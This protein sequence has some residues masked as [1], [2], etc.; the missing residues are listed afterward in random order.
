MIDQNAPT[1]G[2]HS[3]VPAGAMDWPAEIGPYR[4]VEK[5]GQGGMGLVLLGQSETPKR[6]AAIKLMRADA[7]DPDALARFR[8]EMEVLARLEHR[9]IARLY[10]VG[11]LN[12]GAGEKPWYAME[13]VAGLPLDEYVKRHNLSVREILS[14]VSEIARALQFA[15]QKGVIH[16]DIKPA[17]ILVDA[18]GQA[19]LLDFGIA[20]LNDGQ[21]AD[22]RT[23]FGQIIGT[24][25]YMSPEQLASSSQ[26]DV[27]SDVYALGVVLF[28]LLTGE[29]PLKIGTTS[30][31][32]AIKEV[33]EG[34]RK[35]LVEIR[36]EL[37]GEIALIVDTASSRE[38]A[39]R[40]ESASSFAADLENFLAHRPLLAKRPSFFYVFS[41]FVRR[42]PLVVAASALALAALLFATLYSLAAAKKEAQARQSA[43]AAKVQ[44]EARAA[45]ASA[46]LKFLNDAL[47]SAA[48]DRSRGREVKII[49]MLAQASAQRFPVAQAN[50]EAKVRETLLE[51]Y[52]ALGAYPEAQAE[53][54]RLRA[55]CKLA[56]PQL[57]DSCVL[58]EARQ[59]RVLTLNGKHEQALA[60]AQ[61]ALPK[62]RTHFGA[63][64]L[65]AIDQQIELGE[66]YGRLGNSKQALIE[67][68]AAIAQ[69]EN[70]EVVDARAELKFR[71][72][73]SDA[74]SELGELDESESVLMAA[75]ARAE[76]GLG[77]DH[78]T[79]LLARNS[80][81][82]INFQRE[83][84]A[85]AAND[86]ETLLIQAQKVLGPEHRITMTVLGNLAAAQ[87]VLGELAKAEE[88]FSKRAEVFARK[89]PDDWGSIL[90]NAVNRA[91]VQSK[92]QRFERGLSDINAAIEAANRAR[93]DSFPAQLANAYNWQAYFTWKLGQLTKAEA[94]YAELVAKFVAQFGEGDVQ[95]ARYRSRLGQV[96]LALKKREQGRAL[97]EQALP[98]LVKAY[99]DKHQSVLEAQA[100]LVQ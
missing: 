86:F 45:E 61:T 84:Y 68:R 51:S 58:L 15:H 85:R 76:A 65:P 4:I 33:S 92:R 70:S 13:F 96:K 80:L 54:E 7:F 52:L 29:L 22:A 6:R 63:A 1:I 35:K 3:D 48:P 67:I 77:A 11:T 41:K 66:I 20:R 38:L 99:G 95:L 71:T 57:A 21:N 31:I 16:R 93:R 72:V 100:A 55:L 94:I 98:L 79:V 37:R 17:N 5:L 62:L 59:A 53:L 50:V 81:A 24:L 89:Y 64:S 40:Y 90:N 28:E 44:A 56:S 60:L 8:L 34:R 19:K 32:D 97:I 47:A 82:T 49:D 46:V 43:D 36:P 25:A 78:P 88:N 91:S 75:L 9:G 12:D 18:D 74:L 69:M 27:R 2:A 73:L 26:A 39:L 83:D 30:L 87:S 23:R 10:E 42:Q 14:L